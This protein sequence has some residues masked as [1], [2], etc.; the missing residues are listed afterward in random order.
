MV[1][2]RISSRPPSYLHIYIYNI[3]SHTHMHI[4]IYTDTTHANNTHM[5]ESPRA[6]MREGRREETKGN[7]GGAGEGGKWRGERRGRRGREMEGG[8]CLLITAA[9]YV[10]VA[11]VLLMC[12]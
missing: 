8:Q 4:Y 5:V 1:R 3:H 2:G 10:S 11:N 9:T 6:S 7:R 12:Y